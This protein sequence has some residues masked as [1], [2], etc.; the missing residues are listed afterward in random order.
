MD[1]YRVLGIIP[2]RSGSKGIPN[3][4]II[5]ICGKPLM[6]YSIE[7]A[8][9]SKLITDLCLTS[10]SSEYLE[11]GRKAGCK[12][13]ILRD[14]YLANDNAKSIDVVKDAITKMTKKLKKNYD[15]VILLQPT[16]PLRTEKDIDNSIYILRNNDFVD[17]VISVVKTMSHHPNLI[18]KID[19]GLLKPFIYCEIEG[20]RR[21]DYKPDA[22]LRNGSI[23]CTKINTI[24]NKSSLW[25]EKII[26]LIMPEESSV[27][28]DSYLDLKVLE[29]ILK[30]K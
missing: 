12:N 13:L 10:D 24:I 22:Y 8:L 17:S 2:A 27:N 19:K 20:T 23:Y 25:G 11:I 18:K 3:K 21:Q 1:N 16:A 9:N 5:K 6:N 29:A 14:I 7:V 26:P 4:N 15:A 28:V 30:E